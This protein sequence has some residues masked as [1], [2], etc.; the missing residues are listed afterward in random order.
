MVIVADIPCA[1]IARDLGP[2]VAQIGFASDQGH[3]SHAQLSQL[4]YEIEALLGGEL[5]GA[6]VSC[7]RTAVPA[8][9][10]A[11]EGD[12]PNRVNGPP[13]SVALARLA[14]E[15]KVTATGRRA[16]RNRQLAGPRLD[17]LGFT[18]ASVNGSH[19]RDIEP[20]SSPALGRP[21]SQ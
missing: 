13:R 20:Y 12:L 3:L 1:R 10:V 2:V 15:W 9:E 8:G 6:S 7:T 11:L 5:V 21:Q 17:E 19:R 4:P 16:R 18:L 14:R